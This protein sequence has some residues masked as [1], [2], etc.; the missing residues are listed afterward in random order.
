MAVFQRKPKTAGQKAQWEKTRLIVRGAVL[1]FVF[2]YIIVPLLGTVPEDESSMS[3]T[4][5]YII[6]AV[7]T[8]AV[9]VLTVITILEYF[10]YKKSGLYDAAAYKDDEGLSG[11]SDASEASDD[12]NEY[13]DDDEITESDEEDEYEPNEDG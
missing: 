4:V 6:V 3:P 9:A 11:M 1:V 8:V 5:R 2:V 7:F 10:R 12:D 13:E